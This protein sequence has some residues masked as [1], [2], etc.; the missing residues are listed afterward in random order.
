M[1]ELL[2]RSRVA[3]PGRRTVVFI[4]STL[5]GFDSQ[6]DKVEWYRDAA[7]KY[8]TW[9]TTAFPTGVE[10]HHLWGKGLPEFARSA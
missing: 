3:R 7:G 1:A 6:Y 5:S 2:E 4:D 9:R 10:I 8:C